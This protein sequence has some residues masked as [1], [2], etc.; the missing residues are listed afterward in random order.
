[1]ADSNCGCILRSARAISLAQD[2]PSTE[3]E[4]T[5]VIGGKSFEKACSA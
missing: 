2:V 3:I 4:S 5:V 1:M